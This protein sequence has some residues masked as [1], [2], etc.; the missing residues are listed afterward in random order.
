MPSD[1]RFCTRVQPK[2]QRLT[3]K[4]QLADTPRAATVKRVTVLRSTE[5]V[6]KV[7]SSVQVSV[8]V[9]VAKIVNQRMTTMDPIELPGQIET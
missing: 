2:S 4:I 7:G 5:S 8:N 9:K 3:L 1:R 6:S